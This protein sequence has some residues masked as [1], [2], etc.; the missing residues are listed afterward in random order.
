MVKEGKVEEEGETVEVGGRKFDG[1][2]GE[3]A[4][5]MTFRYRVLYASFCMCIYIR[6]TLEFIENAISYLYF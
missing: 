1:K 3:I 5:V 6:C 2:N 4:M